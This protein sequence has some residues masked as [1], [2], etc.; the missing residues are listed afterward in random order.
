M[1]RGRLAEIG[2]DSVWNYS[3]TGLAGF[4]RSV[5]GSRWNSNGEEEHA[6]ECTREQRGGDI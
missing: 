4:D 1:S 3:R 6:K 2:G 5:N